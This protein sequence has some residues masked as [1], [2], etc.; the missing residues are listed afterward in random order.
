[1]KDNILTAGVFVL[2]IGLFAFAANDWKAP[3]SGKPV[4]DADWCEAH[5]VALSTCEICNPKLAR[6]G[7][8]TIKEREAKEG[9]CPNTQV[10]I[11]LGSDAARKVNIALHSVEARP[12]AEILKANA[13]T[14]YAPDRHARVAPRIPGVIKEVRVRLGQEVESGGVLAVVESSELGHLK[15]DHL[16]A[17]S[18]LN[19]RQKTFDR[20]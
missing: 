4:H 2:L 11:V 12:V 14:G 3:W 13:E 16:Q 6:G 17:L 5:Q 7:T 8:Q 15:S 18:V 20:D 1:M 9:E 19:L 10:R